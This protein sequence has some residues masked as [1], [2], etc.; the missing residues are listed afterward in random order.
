M[1]NQTENNM[2]T[3][4]YASVVLII[5]SLFVIPVYSQFDPYTNS[6]TKMP[7][8]MPASGTDTINQLFY[9]PNSGV[10]CIANSF[11]AYGSGG[12]DLFTLNAGVITK[13][14][15]TL[16]TGGFDANLA[17]CNNLDGGAF[18]PTFYSTR[19]LNQPVYYNGAGVTL[20]TAISPDKLFNCGGSGDYLYY[21]RYDTS[22]K[23]DAIVRYNGTAFT[24]IYNLNDS[25]T[26]TVADIAVDSVGNVYFFTG[27]NNG[28]YDTDTLNVV[29]ST[30]QLLK[31]YP[32]PYNTMNG[33]GCFLLNSKLYIG[34]GGSNTNHPNTILP[35]TINASSAIAGTPIAMP[36]TTSYSDMASCTAGSPLSV[37]EPDAMPV[38]TIY[39]NP[40]TD[41]LTVNSNS[42]ESLEF[43]LYDI[44]SREIMQHQFANSITIHTEALA[45]GIYLYTIKNRNGGYKS[46]KIVKN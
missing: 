5:L 25:A 31:K 27:R 15:T 34:L 24:A 22:Y 28:L 6:R 37:Y 32:F 39:P 17:Y 19:S 1:L 44:T 23:A 12:A 30:G 2:K 38:F 9:S 42:G 21:I 13:I 10:D 36:V 3:N 43:T 4:Y 35:I 18:G 16:I 7:V 20:C 46:G 45:K 41:N 11:W 29:S 14:S 33:Y 26:S 40:V 8:V